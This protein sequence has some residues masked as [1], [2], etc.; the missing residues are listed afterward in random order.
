LQ[1]FGFLTREV[2]GRNISSLGLVR[3]TRLVEEFR[4]RGYELEALLFE[5]ALSEETSSPLRTCKSAYKK[6]NKT[7]RLKNE[8]IQLDQN[9]G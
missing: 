1:R 6:S 5:D 2:V 3:S 7:L 4:A 9:T 8:Y